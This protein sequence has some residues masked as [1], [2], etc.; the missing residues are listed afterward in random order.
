MSYSTQ[1]IIKNQKEYGEKIINW[2]SLQFNE[3]SDVL[4]SIET[5]DEYII[6]ERDKLKKKLKKKQFMKYANELFFMNPNRN[7]TYYA[8][9]NESND[10]VNILQYKSHGR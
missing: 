4:N 5:E 6:K 10:E 9:W 2:F 7:K 8:W 1:A 3:T